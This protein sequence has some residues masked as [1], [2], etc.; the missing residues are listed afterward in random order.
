MSSKFFFQFF[1]ELTDL[2]MEDS[3]LDGKRPPSGQAMELSAAVSRMHKLSAECA[4]DKWG[5]LPPYLKSAVIKVC[6]GACSPFFLPVSEQK[7]KGAYTF[8]MFDNVCTSSGGEIS[9]RR[10]T[11]TD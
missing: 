8:V 1:S 3:F 10:V 6:V 2:K 11:A 9:C 5:R 4:K 7:E